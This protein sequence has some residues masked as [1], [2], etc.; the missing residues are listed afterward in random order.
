MT[1]RDL[2]LIFS[3]AWFAT[4]GLRARRQS[5]EP[6]RGTMTDI[7]EELRA[8]CLASQRLSTDDGQPGHAE[9]ALLDRDVRW[10]A[11]TEIDSLRRQLMAAW[12]PMHAAPKD[13]GPLLL[14]CPGLSGHVA[15]EVVVGIWRFDPNR[16]DLG[17]WVSDVGELEH[18]FPSTGPWIEYSELHPKLWAPLP[19]SPAVER[20]E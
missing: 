17:F 8:Q 15:Q 18:G 19:T 20:K 14:F 10:R 7:V 11:A 5:G 13:Q 12:Q 2:L 6:G 9:L 3:G 16:R 4:F 1:L